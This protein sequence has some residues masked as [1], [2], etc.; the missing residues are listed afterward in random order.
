MVPTTDGGGE[1]DPTLRI[2]EEILLINGMETV[3]SI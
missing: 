3:Q 2:K 1:D